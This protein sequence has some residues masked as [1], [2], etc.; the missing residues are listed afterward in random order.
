MVSCGVVT[1]IA[2]AVPAHSPATNEVSLPNIG[3]SFVWS[4]PDADSNAEKRIAAFGVA[5]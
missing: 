2:S 5:K 4:A 1:T 3:P